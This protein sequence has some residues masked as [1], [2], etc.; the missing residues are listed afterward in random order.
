MARS[1]RA[2]MMALHLEGV[3]FRRNWKPPRLRPWEGPFVGTEKRL[4][5]HP[6]VANERRA[7]R[8]RWR[9]R[10]R[11]HAAQRGATETVADEVELD[12]VYETEQQLF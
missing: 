7:A 2:A 4:P 5:Q 3:V 12:D 10:P 6:Q 9:E 8:R 11:V 1:A